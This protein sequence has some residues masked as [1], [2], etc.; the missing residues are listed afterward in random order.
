MGIHCNRNLIESDVYFHTPDRTY[1]R[2]ADFCISQETRG[3]FFFQLF[4][5]TL[6]LPVKTGQKTLIARHYV[7]MSEPGLARGWEKLKRQQVRSDFE[8]DEEFHEMSGEPLCLIATS[9]RDMSVK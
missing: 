4:Q 1:F 9:G 8:I 3:L 2:V 6:S 5:A 7:T